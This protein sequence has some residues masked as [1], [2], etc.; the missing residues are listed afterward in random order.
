MAAKK[1]AAKKAALSKGQAGTIAPVHDYGEM[2]GAGFDNMTAED[3]AIPFLAILQS[4][5]PQLK[6]QR[7][8]YLPDAEEGML[9]DTVAQTLY[10][11]ESGVVLVPCD[12]AH[13]YTEWR[14][15]DA[16]GGYVGQH[17]V[18]SDV[19]QE[20]RER[21]DRFGRYSTAEGNDLV[22]TYYLYGLLL[23]AP[24]AF[25]T[26]QMVML[27]ITSTKIKRYRQLLTRLRNAAPKAPLFAHQVRVRTA[28]ESNNHGDFHNFHFSA[29]GE[30]TAGAMVDPT[31]E[32]GAAFLQHCLDFQKQVREGVL[33]AATES[34]GGS[35]SASEGDIPF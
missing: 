21:S 9:F 18:D 35:E 27:A 32:D 19:V 26:A 22:E 2:A 6:K 15:R 7:T 8:E 3:Y 29:A 30:D 10:S 13:V 11:G 4:G 14:P 17:A 23:D 16:G 25:D 20:A 1:K 34:L 5:S 28:G 24:G 12:R 31:T 33:R